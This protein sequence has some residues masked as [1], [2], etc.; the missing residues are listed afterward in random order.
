MNIH[1]QSATAQAQPTCNEDDTLARRLEAT[2]NFKVLRRLVPRR[3]TPAPAGNT[4]KVGIA[5]DVET[6]GLDP[7]KD[8]IIEVAMV[9]FRYSEAD[10]ITGVSGVFQ[11][12]NEPSVP[13]PALVTELTGITHEM[14]AGHR[15]DIAALEAFVADANIIIAHNAAFDRMF[16]ERLS[17]TFEHKHWACSQTEVDW[18]KHRF[19]GAKLSYILTD[20]GHFHNAHRAID[21]CH[22]LVEILGHQLPATA[23]SVFA[24]LMGCARRTTVRVW[25]Q[26]SPFDLKDALKARGYRWSDGTDGRPRSWFIDVVEDE[27]DAELSYLK[28]EI[29]QRDVGI[30]CQ[31]MTA[32]DRFSSRA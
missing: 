4:N 23:Q 18:R 20:M 22:A 6:T 7:A 16:A 29:Y 27:R 28:K 19:S 32:H 10:E 5:L 11:S 2:G 15:I 13:I 14:V 17:Q 8:D 30:D 26:R 31:V 1:A 3:P 24:E 12:Y 21:D 25:A 9:K